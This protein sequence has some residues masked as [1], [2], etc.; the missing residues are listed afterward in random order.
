[1]IKPVAGDKVIP[2]DLVLPEEMPDSTD[3]DTATIGMSVL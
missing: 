2:D 3:I 1:M